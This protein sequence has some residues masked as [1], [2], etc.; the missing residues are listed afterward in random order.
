MPNAD[1]HNTDEAARITRENLPKVVELMEKADK[2][3][4]QSLKISYVAVGLGAV[5]VII[6]ILPF[7]SKH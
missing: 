1:F 5:A 7:L 6:A 4:R 3:A 2:I